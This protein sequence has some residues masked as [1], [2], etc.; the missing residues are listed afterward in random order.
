MSSRSKVL[1]KGL[2]DAK[3][4][5]CLSHSYIFS[6]SSL[7]DLEDFIFRW[8]PVL[9]CNNLSREKVP[10]G[11]CQFCQRLEKNNYS[12]LHK[13]SSVSKSGQILVEDIAKFQ[14][15]FFYTS[16]EPFKIGIIYEADKMVVQAQNSFLKTLEEP[17][18]NTLF[19]LLTTR[20]Q[21]LLDT[22][23]SRCWHIILPSDYKIDFQDVLVDEFLTLLGGLYPKCGARVALDRAAK[24]E[25]FFQKLKGV[26]Q[27][28]SQGHFTSTDATKEERELW[29]HN[30]YLS[31]REKYLFL[32]ESWFYALYIR[33]N[34]SKNQSR[35]QEFE[36]YYSADDKW[37]LSQVASCIALVQKLLQDLQSNLKPSMAL[38]D[39]CLQVCVL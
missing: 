15:K 18:K 38:N 37:T 4:N 26:C 36:R 39:F 21:K 6:S 31:Y 20:V 10:C 16:D 33:C 30:L 27:L 2:K 29:V 17:S 28:D 11:V 19:I 8:I 9:I 34:N 22:V 32:L 3:A 7:D 23:I 14:E 35:Y 13:L 12:S 1:L 5:G 24:I 25:I